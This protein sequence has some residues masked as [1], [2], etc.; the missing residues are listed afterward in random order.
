MQGRA[1]DKSH[2]LCNSRQRITSEVSKQKALFAEIRKGIIY[3]VN[4]NSNVHLF[5]GNFAKMKNIPSHTQCQF[6]MELG[7]YDKKEEYIFLFVILVGKRIV[8]IGLVQNL[9]KGEKHRDCLGFY[10]MKLICLSWVRLGTF[11]FSQP[12]GG[13]E[14]V[15]QVVC[16]CNR[17]GR[18]A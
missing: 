6:I 11:E 13:A 8:V 5:Q 1:A 12:K 9:L 2:N 15:S 7:T 17:L 18:G 10:C 3:E 14:V 16:I 4:C